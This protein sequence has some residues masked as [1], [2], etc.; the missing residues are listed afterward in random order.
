MIVLS[1]CIKDI[2][3][4]LLQKVINV[5]QKYSVGMSCNFG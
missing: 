3:L 5:L 4:I 1:N 2:S